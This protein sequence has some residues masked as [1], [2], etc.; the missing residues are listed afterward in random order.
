MLKQADLNEVLS[1][2]P[3]LFNGCFKKVTGMQST[4]EPFMNIVIT[5]VPMEEVY[6]LTCRRDY[7]DSFKTC[8]ERNDALMAV[9]ATNGY[10][11]D[12]DSFEQLDIQLYQVCE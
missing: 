11:Y 10:E 8:E 9:L 12:L 4:S 7:W 3:L 2:T 1:K 5:A 6:I